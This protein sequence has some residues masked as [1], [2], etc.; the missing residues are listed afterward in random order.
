MTGS[1]LAVWRGS[2][3]HYSGRNGYKVD[4]I[5]LHIMVGTLAGTDT[6]FRRA[7]FMAASHYG[8]GGTGLIYQ[9]VDETNGSWADANMASDCS[10]VTIEHEGGLAG[11]PVTDKEIEASA[12][13]C[14]DI[15]R[16]YKLGRLYHDGVNGNI[17]LHREIPGTDHA[18]CPDRTADNPLPVQRILD[19]ANQILGYNTNNKGD[20]DMVTKQEIDAI[21]TAVWNKVIAQDGINGKKGKPEA[22][23]I[24]LYWVHDRGDRILSMADADK[25]GRNTLGKKI[26]D[27]PVD[28]KSARDRL[29]ATSQQV[30][31]LT[32]TVTAQQAAIDTL[33]KS[34]GAD[35]AQIAKTVQDAVRAK[36]D[37][38]QITVTASEKER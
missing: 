19:R 26:W 14:A 8:V 36:L 3:N 10:G 16:R 38:L 7:S 33:A 12:R 35:P 21:A 2:P 27:Y 25:D 29:L 23:W 5:T 11:I 24:K 20:D 34:L 4:H 17:Y 6:C 13:L 18:G 28:G 15:A 1:S 9:W 30:A 37:A 31:T 22:A 32:A